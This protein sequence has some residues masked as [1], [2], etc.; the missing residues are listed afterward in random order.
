MMYAGKCKGVASH[1]N[2]NSARGVMV[3]VIGIGNG[4]PSSNSGRGCLHFI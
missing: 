2:D 1:D 4:G 3:T